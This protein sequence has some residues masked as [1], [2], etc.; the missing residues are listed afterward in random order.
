MPRSA[1]SHL[2]HISDASLPPSQEHSAEL[3]NVRKALARMPTDQAE[4]LHLVGVLGFTYSEAA[5]LLGIP[6]GTVMSRL[7]R[8][9]TAL[10]QN[11]ES[12]GADAVGHLK[13]VG[14]RDA[15]R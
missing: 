9:R 11:M 15:V 2:S 8:A 3:S 14:G 13:V 12:N 1:A 10:K 4:I 5:E 6:A 7:S